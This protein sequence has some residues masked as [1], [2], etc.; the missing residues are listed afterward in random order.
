MKGS[1][2]ELTA[3]LRR[4]GQSVAM[5]SGGSLLARIQSEY[6]QD[7]SWNDWKE[8]HAVSVSV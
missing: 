5:L 6:G 8:C 2:S 7:M 1:W 4:G 3:G